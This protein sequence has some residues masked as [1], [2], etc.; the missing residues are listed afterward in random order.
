M[1]DDDLKSSNFFNVAA[2]P[3]MTFQSTK[4]SK[5]G[6]GAAKMTGNLT[7]HGVTKEVTFDVKDPAP[8]ADPAGARRSVEA[9]A[10][11][12]R[13]AFGVNADSAMIGDDVSITLDV[14]LVKAANAAH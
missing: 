5:T 6:D 1:R 13:K 8:Q 2:Y 3:T 14:Q 9:T 10:T 11:I 4:I 7:L 12:S